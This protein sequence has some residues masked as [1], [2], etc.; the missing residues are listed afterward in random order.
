MIEPITYRKIYDEKGGFSHLELL[1]GNNA[2]K[3]SLAG[4]GTHYASN[5]WEEVQKNINSLKEG[6]L[7]EIS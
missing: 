4:K 1:Q 3:I 5:R 2:I 6:T 7:K